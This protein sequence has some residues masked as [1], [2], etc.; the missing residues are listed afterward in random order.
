[1][2]GHE[3]S[4]SGSGSGSG[5][6]RRRSSSSRFSERAI[7]FLAGTLIGGFLVWQ[8]VLPGM[9]KSLNQ[10]LVTTSAEMQAKLQAQVDE[11]QGLE[12]AL[13]ETE[14]Q[15]DMLETINRSVI[16]AAVLDA[17]SDSVSLMDMDVIRLSE[18]QVEPDASFVAILESAVFPGGRMTFNRSEPY[19]F[20]LGGDMYHLVVRPVP[21]YKENRL[22]VTLFSGLPH[23][24]DSR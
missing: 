16:G 15:A 13:D 12:A 9:A 3:R 14:R 1:M 19:E 5:R 4:R 18:S 20:E 17:K 23:R 21:P 8:F 22:R 6:S 2:N 24:D 10:Q 11:S 7:A